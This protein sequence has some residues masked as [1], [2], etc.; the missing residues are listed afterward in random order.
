[1]MSEA[2]LDVEDLVSVGWL[3]CG[4]YY[5]TKEM[6]RKRLYL[7][8]Q[9]IMKMYVWRVYKQSEHYIVDQLLALGGRHLKF[10]N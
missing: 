5:K 7:N 6:A 3:L 8:S 9:Q 4:R 10:E 1:M 2:G